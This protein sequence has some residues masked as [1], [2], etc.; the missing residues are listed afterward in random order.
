MAGLGK[1]PRTPEGVK[2]PIPRTPE[3]PE[4]P[5]TVLWL[6]VSVCLGLGFKG[7]QPRSITLSEKRRHHRDPSSLISGEV[8]A[9]SRQRPPVQITEFEFLISPNP[10]VSC[11]PG[12]ILAVLVR[13][14]VA[15]TPPPWGWAWVSGRDEGWRAP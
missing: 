14:E 8:S 9:V 1:V 3:T 12:L 7:R 11:R 10:S 2:G 13:L 5:D 6:G 4:D 15:R